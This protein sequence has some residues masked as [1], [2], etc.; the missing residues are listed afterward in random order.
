MWISY[1]MELKVLSIATSYQSLHAAV[2]MSLLVLYILI[3]S[4]PQYSTEWWS[5]GK[6]ERKWSLLILRQ[7]PGIWLENLMKT[8][9][10]LCQNSQCHSQNWYRIQVR[11]ITAWVT[12]F[13]HP[14]VVL[15]Y[16]RTAW[17][18]D[19]KHHPS[20]PEQFS[21][22][23]CISPCKVLHE[24]GWSWKISVLSRCGRAM[25]GSSDSCTLEW[26]H[27]NLARLWYSK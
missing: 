27:W 10:H 9:E 21:V 22:L 15:R 6:L 19:R 23:G 14:A 11:S 8:T 20:R 16:R 4:V 12:L 25:E 1:V 17:H 5:D 13:G 3:V 24:V 26:K 2:F 18:R 7:Y